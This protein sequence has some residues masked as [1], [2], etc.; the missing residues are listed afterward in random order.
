M[1]FAR[2][3]ADN[4][5]EDKGGFS[6]SIFLLE[7]EV[8]YHISYDFPLFELYEK[9]DC[10]KRYLDEKKKAYDKGKSKRR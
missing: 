3:K 9:L 8:G 4:K 10:F 1:F 2:L 5:Q 6:Y 7:R